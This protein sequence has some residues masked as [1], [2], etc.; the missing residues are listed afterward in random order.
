MSYVARILILDHSIGDYHETRNT[1]R[2]HVYST[3]RGILSSPPSSTP[4][5]IS[6]DL[7]AAFVRGRTLHS[8]RFGLWPRQ[9]FG[10]ISW[11]AAR[12]TPQHLERT[13]TASH[14]KISS[15]W[16][17]SLLLIAFAFEA[18]FETLSRPLPFRCQFVPRR[19]DL[20]DKLGLSSP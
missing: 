19:E 4:G 5:N 13:W 14:L 6:L 20:K 7:V 11:L 17:R 9:F 15:E 10:R 1:T 2:I 12:K 18:D 3:P 8:S 16:P